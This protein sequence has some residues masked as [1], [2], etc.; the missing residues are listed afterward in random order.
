MKKLKIALSLLFALT[1]SLFLVA[2]GGGK[3]VTEIQLEGQK[4]SFVEGEAFSTGDLTVTVY[5]RGSDEPVVL[6][7][8]QYEVDSSAY[9]PNQASEYSIVITPEQEPAEGAQP[10]TMTYL[11][12]VE[13]NWQDNGDGTFSCDCGASRTSLS[14]LTDTVTTVAWGNQATLTEKSENSPATAPRAGENHVSYGV[15]VAGQSMELT[16]KILEVDTGA[17]WNTPLM[18]VRNGAVGILPREDNY[19]IGTVAGFT[20]PD[21][22]TKDAAVAGI[23]T[24]TAETGEWVVYS[25]GSTWTAADLVGGTDVIFYNYGMDGIM[26]IRHTLTKADNSTMTLT[27]TFAV[28]DA[29]YEIVAYGEKV[30]YQVTAIESVQNRYVTDFTAELPTATEQAEGKMFD[31]TGIQATAEMSAGDPVL[32]S[33][34]AYAYVDVAN[35]DGTTTQTRVNLAS[36]PLSAEM[37]AFNLEFAGKTYFFTS[38]NTIDGE[39]LITVVPSE[40]TTAAGAA[41]VAN[42]Y[43]FDAPDATFDYAVNAA[44]DGIDVVGAGKAA[45]LTADQKTALDTEASNFVSLK[46]GNLSADFD[47]VEISEGYASLANGVISVVLPVTDSTTTVTLTLKKGDATVQTVS[48]DVSD[49]EKAPDVGVYVAGSDFTLDAGGTYTVVY[50]GIPASADDYTLVTGGMRSTV[51]DVKAAITADGKYTALANQLY[52]NS[53]E[54]GEEGL[55]VVYEIAKPNL[56]N[57]SA[58]NANRLVG[59]RNADGETLAEVTLHYNMVFSDAP[60]QGGNVA[61]VSDDVYVYVARDKMFVMKA[62]SAE[63]VEG[64]LEYAD[65]VFNVTL[66]IQNELGLSYDLSVSSAYDATTATSVV[67]AVASNDITSDLGTKGKLVALGNVGDASDYDYGALLMLELSVTTLGLRTEDVAQTYYF[68]ANEDTENGQDT[69]TVFT[70]TGDEIT[71]AEVTPA[72]ERTE[73]QVWSCVTDGIEAYVDETTGF[74]YGAVITPA[75]GAHEFGE[76]VDNKATCS[77]CGASSEIFEIDENSF[78]EVVLLTPNVSE[79]I[80]NTATDPNG[81]WSTRVGAKELSGDFA[82]KY[83][84]T[85][86]DQ[87]YVADGAIVLTQADYEEGTTPNGLFKRFLEPATNEGW[88]AIDS[89]DNSALWAA[90]SVVTYNVYKNGEASSFA[91]ATAEAAPYW[92]DGKFEVTAVRLGTNLTVTETVTASNGDVWTSVLTVTNFT[93]ANLVSEIGGNVYWLADITVNIGTVSQTTDVAVGDGYTINVETINITN[94]DTSGDWWTGGTST[95]VV[96]GDFAIMY[97]WDNVRDVTWAQDAVIEFID[98]ENV[99][100]DLNFL[101]CNAWTNPGDALA[102][103][104]VTSERYING[105]AAE[106]SDFPMQGAAE[107]NYGGEYT[108]YVVR[109]GSTLMIYQTLT[110]TDGDVYTTIDTISGYTTS[111]LTASITGNPYWLDN[112]AAWVGTFTK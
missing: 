64:K 71:S 83:T 45:V 84:W 55:T 76:Y 93:K 37:Y 33:Y 69:Y 17:T 18:G 51:A 31:T 38:D 82:V 34:N 53:V 72:G 59:I 11:V 92:L 12:T 80:R 4:T 70:V 108:V 13:H 88:S 16:L 44:G 63:E 6:E 22:G 24:A 7:A 109:D 1:F 35:E 29:S 101:Q 105:E 107:T 8:D 50:T 36:E 40:F 49:V 46:L 112:I 110:N 25:S 111:A 28:P 89:V 99:A 20:T 73:T 3:E 75:S 90:D 32:N 19:V 48:I 106:A 79:S 98:S 30:T 103:F 21:G 27:Y 58:T 43:T 100:L 77:V 81:W 96:E 26:T 15:L 5:Y 54:E 74:K 87:N 85:N 23:G 57:L 41:V 104:E 60:E 10:V 47:A 14:G 102:A 97:T 9:N 42:G 66:N 67:S 52:I 78:Y 62:F 39:D 2:C 56:A 86:T 61:K 95:F 94:N 91:D 65:L 68:T